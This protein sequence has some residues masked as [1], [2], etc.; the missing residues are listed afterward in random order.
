MTV[1]LKPSIQ[2]VQVTK[3]ATP[4]RLVVGLQGLMGPTGSIPVTKT[5]DFTVAVT[6]NSLICNKGSTLA[7]TLPAA[8][9]YPGRR[10]RIKTIQ[11]FTVVSA[12]SNVV[13]L[14][15]GAAAAAILAATAGK[16]AD[17]ESDGTNWV[18]TAGN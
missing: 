13:P 7:V 16:W 1:I 14:A 3:Q 9:T 2:T 10:I 8:S 17:L 12:S 6:E 4:N 18:I 5:G 15:G 11:A